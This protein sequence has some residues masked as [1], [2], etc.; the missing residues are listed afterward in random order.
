MRAFLE[1]HRPLA[2]L[3]LVL[4]AQLLLLAYQI[5][6][7]NQMRLLRLWAVTLVTPVERGL[8][9]AVDSV[10]SV[11]NRYIALYGVEGENRA[12][13][14]EL[15]RARLRLH[16][17]EARATE[18]EQ[19]AALLDLKQAHPQAPLI[20]AEIIGAS[21]AGTSRALFV[22]RG[23]QDGL[24]VNM[25]VLTADGIV[26]KI[27]QVFP[28]SAQLL[29]LTDRDSG[30]GAMLANS[31]VQGV[32]KGTGGSLCQ[33]AYVS[34][35]EPVTVGDRVLASGQDQLF[36]KGFPIGT[37]ASVQPGEYFQEVLVLPT[38]QLNRLEYVFVLAGAPGTLTLTA[39]G[40]ARD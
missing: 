39:D 24:R 1:R 17:L 16:G 29:L 7:E 6:T 3:A 18:A 33:L 35:E 37:V 22:N 34:N 40:M 31:R 10:A 19:L 30:L 5:K 12:L 38:A 28:T 8:D 21:A 9:I 14:A 25:V 20:A 2:L 36:P 27:I 15:E 26:G 13:R 32:V 11:W 23:R 4:F